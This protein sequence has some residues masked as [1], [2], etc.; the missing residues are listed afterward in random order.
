MVIDDSALQYAIQISYHA[1]SPFKE[2]VK[3][4][5]TNTPIKLENEQLKEEKKQAPS[6][7]NF[8][9]LKNQIQA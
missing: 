4:L 3:E 5:L 1:N 2:K 9:K 7:E 6:L 8:E